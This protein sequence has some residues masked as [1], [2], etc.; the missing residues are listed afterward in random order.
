MDLLE[1]LSPIS[2]PV[3]QS[4]NIGA[5]ARHEAKR[6]TVDMTWTK[7]ED[8]ILR[9]LYPNFS[10][11]A[12]VLRHRSYSALRGRAKALGIQKRKHIWTNKDTQRLRSV[13][14]ESAAEIKAAFPGMAYGALKKKGRD[15]GFPSRGRPPFA[16]T[17]DPCCDAIRDRC[18]ELGYSM[19][20][21]DRIARTSGYFQKA[22]WHNKKKHLLGP[23]IKAINALGG[24]FSVQFPD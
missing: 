13:W 19:V 20:E 4:V 6:A 5:L 8:T 18:R 16:L 21:L 7:S 11:M 17:G 14:R 1:T 2:K 24:T 3:Q 10:S 22:D 12:E 9:D 15:L 23:M